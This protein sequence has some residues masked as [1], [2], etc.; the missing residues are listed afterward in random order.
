MAQFP[1][2]GFTGFLRWILCGL[3]STFLNHGL[4]AQAISGS[5]RWLSFITWVVQS[6]SSIGPS[7]CQVA[8]VPLAV[9]SRYG[10]PPPILHNPSL[11]VGL[12]FVELVPH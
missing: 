5:S 12:L 8:V 10:D 1:N 9:V 2:L 3:L 6:Q 4:F 7:L 11:I